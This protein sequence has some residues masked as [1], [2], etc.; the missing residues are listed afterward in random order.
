VV[1]LVG[2]IDENLLAE[3]GSSANVSVTRLTW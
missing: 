1:V 3:L 2:A